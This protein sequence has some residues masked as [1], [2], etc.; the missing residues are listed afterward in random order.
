MFVYI[1][2]CP[3]AFRCNGRGAELPRP[4]TC[5]RPSSTADVA[6]LGASL[7]KDKDKMTLRNYAV[8]R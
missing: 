1:A 3:L 8:R 4:V 5:Q 2:A 7:G 6:L